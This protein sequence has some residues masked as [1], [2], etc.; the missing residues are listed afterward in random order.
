MT[1]MS[2]KWQLLT[3][4]KFPVHTPISWFEP[5]SPGVASWRSVVSGVSHENEQE[6]G[7]DHDNLQLEEQD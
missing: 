1:V 3:R 5:H 6:A 7:A 2:A 4:A